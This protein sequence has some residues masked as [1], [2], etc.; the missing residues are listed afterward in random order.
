[1]DVIEA[2]RSFKQKIEKR[3]HAR[4]EPP[5]YSDIKEDIYEAYQDIL[6][7]LINY[8]SSRAQESKSESK[9]PVQETEG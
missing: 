5:D 8:E 4:T 7:E 9:K 6:E 3:I 2:L 1:M